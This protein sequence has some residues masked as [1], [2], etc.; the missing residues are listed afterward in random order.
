MKK[1]YAPINTC[2]LYPQ[3][4]S[5]RP[6]C[7]NVYFDGRPP[8]KLAP[9]QYVHRPSMHTEPVC[10]VKPCTVCSSRLEKS[11]WYRKKENG[12]RSILGTRAEDRD[13][14]NESCDEVVGQ[15]PAATTPKTPKI[16]LELSLIQDT[17]RLREAHPNL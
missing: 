3:L 11:W 9:S 10:T 7:T 14:A 1:P 6:N 13:V 12:P 4:T 2:L 16:I 5:Q 17:S 15:S 8:T